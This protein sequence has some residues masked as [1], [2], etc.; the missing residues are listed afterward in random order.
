[1]A[2]LIRPTT[3]VT[4]LLLVAATAVAASTTSAEN[5]AVSSSRD[6]PLKA[7]PAPGRRGRI[8]GGRPVDD[9]DESTGVHFIAKL[10]TRDDGFYCGGTVVSDYPHV[11]TRAGCSPQVGDIVRLG[12][13]RLFDGLVTRVRAVAVHHK[14][15]PVG[16]VADVAVLTLEKVKPWKLRR[17]GVLPATLNKK[18]DNPHGLY[19]TGYG[20]TDKAAQSAGSLQLK[21][22]YLPVASWTHCRKITDAIRVPGLS[23]VGLPINPNAQVCL[24]G[25][26][27]S[28]AL[29]ERDVGGPMFRVKNRK[30]N[31]NG[32]TE[33]VRVYEL[34]AISSFWIAT[35]NE[36]CPQGMPNIGSKVAEYYYWIQGQMK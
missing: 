18:W 23:R 27:R 13:A 22:G 26:N 14:Y 10:F 3:L 2:R 36:R 16:D 15:N 7:T 17:A 35:T 11:L 8:V 20:A 1:M 12:G 6:H 32:Q 30:I 24:W 29:C 33:T 31:H 5:V 25:S 34:Y 19:L 21:R 4:S 28:G 9:L